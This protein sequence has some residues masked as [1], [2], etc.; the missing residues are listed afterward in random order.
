M[1]EIEEGSGNVYADLNYPDAGEMQVKAHLAS[2]ICSIIKARHLTQTQ[3][4]AILG[5]PQPK[6]SE[7]IRGRFRGISETKMIDCL[8][9]LGRDVQIVVKAA[10][11]S[12]PQGR[13]EVIFA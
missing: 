1:S 3:A 13:I 11:R 6:V 12:R 9:R 10:P 4:A 2:K 5:L 8:A 7:M